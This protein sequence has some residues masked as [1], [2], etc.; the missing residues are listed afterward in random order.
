MKGAN[1]HSYNKNIMISNQSLKNVDM[2]IYTR[3]S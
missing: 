1:T 3:H 2:H